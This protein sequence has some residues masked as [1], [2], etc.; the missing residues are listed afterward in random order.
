M[1]EDPVL[2]TPALETVNSPCFVCGT[3]QSE[4]R[5]RPDVRRWGYDGLFLL[6]RCRECGLVYN[7][8]RL[9]QEELADLYRRNYYFF[10]RQTSTEISRIRQAYLRTIA[11]IPGLQPG[12]LLE[13]GSAKGYML[14]LLAGLG[15]SVAGV[16]IADIAAEY[17]RQRFGVPVFT[18]TLEAFTRVN[19][20]TF[21]VVLAQ[22][23]LEHVPEPA[24]FLGAARACLRPGGWLVIDTPNVGGRNVGSLGEGWRGFNPFHIYLFD[25]YTLVRAVARAGFVVQRLG[26]YN[27]ASQEAPVSSAVTGLS[28]LDNARVAIRRGVDRTLLGHYLRRAVRRVKTSSALPLDPE[29]GGDNLVCIAEAR[30]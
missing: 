18:G 2:E 13:V 7:S 12:S 28:A 20:R 9:R 8:P 11:N 30:G 27:E 24:A 10:A 25:R 15:W 17:S 4:I 1:P 21:D 23:V 29:C 6:R 5:Y 19:Q 22:D 26:S 16:E 3:D 14:A